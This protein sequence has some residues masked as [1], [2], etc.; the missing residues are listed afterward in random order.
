MAEAYYNFGWVHQK[1]GLLHL[2][3]LRTPYVYFIGIRTMFRAAKT[4]PGFKV[5]VQI[6]G[7]VVGAFWRGYFHRGLSAL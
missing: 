6:P 7:Y 5:W 2:Q 3:I 4:T 1:H